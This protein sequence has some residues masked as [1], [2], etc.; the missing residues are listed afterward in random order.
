MFLVGGG[1]LV[2]GI[3]GGEALV[4]KWAQSAEQSAGAVVGFVVPSLL[5]GIVGLAAGG[6]LVAIFTGVKKLLPQ[7]PAA[8]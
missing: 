3:P 1:I 4:A 8:A 7:K 2:H 6:L 5:N